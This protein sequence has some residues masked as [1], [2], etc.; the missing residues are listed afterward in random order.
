MKKIISAKRALL[1]FLI[2][3]FGELNLIVSNITGKTD[4]VFIFGLFY[5]C[6]VITYFLEEE[7]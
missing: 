7:K 6:Y 1:V 2:M 3:L 5:I 4:Y